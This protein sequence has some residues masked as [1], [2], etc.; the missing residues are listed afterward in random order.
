MEKS[1]R[2][3]ARPWYRKKRFLL[4]LALL[5]LIVIIGVSISSSNKKAEVAAAQTCVGK[6]YPDQQK[7][8]ICADATNTLLLKGAQVT[9]AP[10]ATR[11]DALGGTALCSTV[12][13]KNAA[14][15]NLDYNVFDFKV[16]P[17]SG[18]V[19][20]TSTLSLGSTLGS[21]TLIAGGTKSG[22]VCSDDKP[23]RGQYV[24]IYKPNP[25]EADRGIWLFPV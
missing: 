17:P 9:A 25:F 3:A 11:K 19:S 12:T 10:F 6:T 15:A 8:D 18:D 22:L 16:Q 13:I 7:R 23:E 2:K 4:P 14:G 20:S 21:G 1:Y 5:V 24:F